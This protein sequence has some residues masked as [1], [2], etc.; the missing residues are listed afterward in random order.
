MPACD[1]AQAL[2]FIQ[3]LFAN[4]KSGWIEI[5]SLHRA[6][7]A[8]RRDW[9]QLPY[10][11]TG[12][13]AK[14][15]ALHCTN[16]AYQQYDVYCGVCP[17]VEPA[18]AGR[19]GGR[20]AVHLVGAAWVDMD[21]KVP[22]SC[23][24][25][26]DNCD[27]VVGSGNGWHGYKLLMTPRNVAHERDKKAVEATIRGFAE[28]LLTGTDNVSNC[29]RI[30]RVPG[31]LNWKDINQPKPVELLRCPGRK[32]LAKASP[33]LPLF[34]DAKFD[35]MLAAALGGRL[36]RAVPRLY[37]NDGGIVDDLDIA[38]VGLWENAMR[39]NN[40]ARWYWAA[41]MATRE[42]PQIAA[43]LYGRKSK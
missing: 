24:A 11:L 36:G 26:L 22:G 34:D 29:D 6:S 17:R 33:W 7:S 8:V 9:L 16:L 5:R 13:A 37:L 10:D 27:I 38:V 25:V 28:S 32:A 40:D 31:T 20:D 43:Y 30:L 39:A 19:K 23:Q 15:M 41:D 18:G 42:V 12:T 4:Y 2:Q 1:P 35:A 3:Q 21:G 14:H